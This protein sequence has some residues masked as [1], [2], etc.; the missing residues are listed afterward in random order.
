MQI[1]VDENAVGILMK[2]EQTNGTPVVD[3]DDIDESLL[4]SD[5]SSDKDHRDLIKV[6]RVCNRNIDVVSYD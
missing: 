6:R 2:N 3:G 4:S 1:A 5:S